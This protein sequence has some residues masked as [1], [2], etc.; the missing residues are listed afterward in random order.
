MSVRYRCRKTQRALSI[1]S[2]A[3]VWIYSAPDMEIGRQL[4]S[5]MFTEIRHKVD[6]RANQCEV[7]KFTFVVMTCTHHESYNNNHCAL[8]HHDRH[9]SATDA[10]NA[11][12]SRSTY[13]F[14]MASAADATITCQYRR[15]QRQQYPRRF[16]REESTGWQMRRCV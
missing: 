14:T 13:R 7:F 12:T 3:C 2:C 8:R 9:W 10:D 6:A 15:R 4:G 11:R 5:Q 16:V 1:I